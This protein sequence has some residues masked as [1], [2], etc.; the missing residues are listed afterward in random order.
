MHTLLELPI[1]FLISVFC[2]TGCEQKA[3]SQQQLVGIWQ[4]ADFRDDMQLD[5]VI[6]QGVEIYFTDDANMYIRFLQETTAGVLPTSFQYKYDLENGRL[7]LDFVEASSDIKD[8]PDFNVKMINDGIVLEVKADGENFPNKPASYTLSKKSE[9]VPYGYTDAE[10]QEILN[11]NEKIKQSIRVCAQKYSEAINMPVLEIGEYSYISRNVFLGGIEHGIIFEI[12]NKTICIT[13]S[14]L[15][16]EL[17]ENEF[18]I[19]AD[20]GNDAMSYAIPCVVSGD[21]ALAYDEDDK[22][23]KEWL[24]AFTMLFP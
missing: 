2:L 4:T 14:S 10:K 8:M 5:L 18:H 19:L 12:Q 21:F 23:P 22:P 13:L 6:G 20:A 7:I 3:V 11:D 16:G 9:V 24:D 1:I 17:W 15:A